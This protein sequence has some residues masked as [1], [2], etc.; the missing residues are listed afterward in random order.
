MTTVTS[1][2]ITGGICKL[3]GSAD[4][5]TTWYDLASR[6]LAAAGTFND[7]VTGAHRHLRVAITSPITG[8]GAVDLYLT[9]L[10]PLNND[11]GFGVS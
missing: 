4:G 8:G 1:G 7:A 3:Q 6:T 10:G 2:I 5:G 9:M 11:S